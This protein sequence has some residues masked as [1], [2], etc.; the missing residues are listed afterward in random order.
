MFLNWKFSLDRNFLS[1][2][3]LFAEDNLFARSLNI[4][5]LYNLCL[6]I[7]TWTDQSIGL[8]HTYRYCSLFSVGHFESFRVSL[9]IS[10]SIRWSFSLSITIGYWNCLIICLSISHLNRW[11]HGLSITIGYWNSLIICLSIWIGDW[12]SLC[13]SLS[14]SYHHCCR[15]SLSSH[16][17]W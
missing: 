1:L 6:G 15:L 3:I 12:N 17:K 11:S 5:H 2:Y 7:C 14:I 8:S 4:G 16:F 13:L 9:S 10:H